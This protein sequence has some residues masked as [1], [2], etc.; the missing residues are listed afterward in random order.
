MDRV[1]SFLSSTLG[2]VTTLA[3][4]AGGLFGVYLFLIA[5]SAELVARQQ[6]YKFHLPSMALQQDNRDSLVAKQDTM[7]SRLYDIIV[8]LTPLERR[9]ELHNSDAFK[10]PGALLDFPSRSKQLLSDLHVLTTLDLENTG[11]KTLK[12]LVLVYATQGYYEYTDSH[13]QVRHGRFTGK[14]ELDNLAGGEKVKLYLWT[15]Y[16]TPE[17]PFRITHDDGAV[18][19]EPV[20]E[21]TGWVR[22]LASHKTFLD[23]LFLMVVLPLAIAG[24]MLRIWHQARLKAH[25]AQQAAEDSE[26]S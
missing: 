13:E 26:A 6:A 5:P 2:A 11:D 3:T 14:L 19:A 8:S 17:A 25:A 20:L 15:G 12:G 21:A 22:W 4:I 18:T 10:R 1:K 7:L 23:L 16:G 9:S 24:G